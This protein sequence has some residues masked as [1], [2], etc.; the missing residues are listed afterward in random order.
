M[1]LIVAVAVIAWVVIRLSFG[2]YKVLVR[3]SLSL[4]QKS[5]SLS[6]L[7]SKFWSAFWIWLFTMLLL[8]VIWI[9][10][11]LLAL[12]PFFCTDFVNTCRSHVESNRFVLRA[13]LVLAPVISATASWYYLTFDPP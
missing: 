8:Y 9:F 7:E 13:Y 11:H 10:V 6:S 4:S 5:K 12:T 1:P 2:L 3:K